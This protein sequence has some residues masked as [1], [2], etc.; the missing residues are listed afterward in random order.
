MTF[1]SSSTRYFL[2][3]VSLVT[4][5]ISFQAVAQTNLALNKPVI[6]SSSESATYGPNKALDG[7]S[8]TRWA[9]SFSDSNWISVDLGGTYTVDKVKLNWETAYAKGYQ[10]Q[11]SLDN[12]N[13][14][15]VYTTTNGN[16]GV[17]EL[18]LSQVARYVRMNGTKRATEWGYSLWDFEVYGSAYT[19]TPTKIS[20]KKTATAS[21][22]VGADYAPALVLDGNSSTRWSSNHA[23]NNWIAIDLGSNH[24]ITGAKL[25]WEGAYGKS[26]QIQ[27]SNDKSNWTT[28]YS[29]T[30]GDGGVDNLNLNGTGR[31]IRMNGIK[32]A[33][34]W[35]YSLWEFEVFGYQSNGTSTSS[36]SSSSSSVR[37]SSSSSVSSSVS[38]SSSV[39]NSS[40]SVS[41]T[42]QSSSS[43]SGG[44][45]VGGVT[46]DWYVPTERENGAYLELDEI[47][48]YEIKY[49]KVS[50]SKFT[51]VQINDGS[52]DRYSLGNL[53]GTYEF[54]IATIDV[55]GVYSEFI[56]VKPY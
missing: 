4:S 16:G 31:Y 20:Y 51:V 45:N 36:S 30:N 8:Y 5:L 37:S 50:D 2:F 46:L 35:G 48:G 11:V 9:S 13:W 32:R 14:T 27:T 56:E 49:K 34:E 42:N 28:I 3:A 38:S 24:T 1:S 53:S 39:S 29:T 25:H 54:Y 7:N 52:V 10:L 19:Q 47:G 18:S 44:S 43:S 17:D 55:N 26:Y 6:A 21:T 23:D 15:T 12:S 33:T 22:Y 40:S 41:S